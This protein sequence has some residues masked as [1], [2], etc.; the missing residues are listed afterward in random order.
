M[1]IIKNLKVL[2]NTT[3][4]LGVCKFENVIIFVKNALISDIVV[5]PV[6][7][8]KIFFILSP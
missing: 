8:S 3:E 6:E 1:E 7:I 2:D 4:G 5:P